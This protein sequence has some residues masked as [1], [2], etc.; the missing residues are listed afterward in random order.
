MHATGY[1]VQPREGYKVLEVDTKKASFKN[2]PW[3]Q[4]GSWGRQK[5]ENW[6]FFENLKIPPLLPIKVLYIT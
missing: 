1:K 5:Y 6:I 4:M 3:K 2:R